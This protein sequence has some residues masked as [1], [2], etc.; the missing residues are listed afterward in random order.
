MQYTNKTDMPLALAVMFASDYYPHNDDPKTISVTTLLNP[1]KQIILGMR[2]TG[3]GQEDLSDRIASVLGTANHDA[4]TKAWTHPNLPNVLRSIGIP[5]KDIFRFVING[6]PLAGTFP[7]EP[8]HI[9]TEVRIKKELLG[10]TISGERDISIKEQ[11]MDMKNEKGYSWMKQTNISKHIKQKSIYRWLDP[12]NLTQDTGWI[13]GT[14][15]DW[16]LSD[17]RKNGSSYP[18]KVF[19]Q[20]VT[21]LSLLETEEFLKGVLLDIDKYLDVPE[22]QLPVCTPEDLWQGKGKWKYYTKVGNKT[23]AKGGVFDN[24]T[25]AHLMLSQRGSGEV[26][27]YPELAKKCNWCKAYSICNQRKQL[28]MQ[29][30][31]AEK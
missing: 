6:S 8:I 2:V 10:W 9:T 23:A 31:L 11:V 1:L 15:T 20:E 27:N 22:D 28:S 30:L 4:L 17:F 24:S 12:K 5:D 16:N 25:E 14:T 18:L 21:L 3:E 29:G 7:E 13:L 26:R 19:G